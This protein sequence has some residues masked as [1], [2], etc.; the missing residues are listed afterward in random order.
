LKHVAYREKLIEIQR[1]NTFRRETLK[2]SKKTRYKP[3]RQGEISRFVKEIPNIPQLLRMYLKISLL[4][5]QKKKSGTFRREKYRFS[6]RKV[7]L[8]HP[9]SG[10]LL[11]GS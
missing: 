10:T 2:S 1:D 4:Q 7:P 11:N 3:K 9:K 8:F 5:R 6:M